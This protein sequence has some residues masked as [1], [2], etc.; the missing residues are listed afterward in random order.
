[1]RKLSQR[2]CVIPL[3]VIA[4]CSGQCSDCGH[5]L[6]SEANIVKRA[7]IRSAEHSVDVTFYTVNRGKYRRAGVLLTSQ[8][9]GESLWRHEEDGSGFGEP[10]GV[11]N[12]LGLSEPQILEYRLIGASCEG[13]LAIYRLRGAD[14]QTL[15]APWDGV[16]Q[17]NLLLEDVDGDGIPEITFQPTL[18]GVARVIFK[19]DG[20][21]FVPADQSFPQYFSAALQDAI[22]Y[23]L[24]PTPVPVSARVAP[25][26]E[27]VRMFMIQRRFNEGLLF[28]ERLLIA[29]SDPSLSLP[30]STGA[31]MPGML[32]KERRESRAAVYRLKGDLYAATGDSV[33]ADHEYSKERELMTGKR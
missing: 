12:I 30:N 8:K 15:S 2:I 26:G 20:S 14:V 10:T 21:Q 7:G 32:E 23:A 18:H 31:Y 5:G 28:C 11:Q 1:M 27:A 16:C 22:R 4:A 6:P 33:A 24:S 3:I 25:G 13:V 17:N 29:V 19:W 9:T